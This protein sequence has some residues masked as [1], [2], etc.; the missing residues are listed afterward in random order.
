M[1][2]AHEFPPEVLSA[3]EPDATE[4]ALNSLLNQ[5]PAVY[6]YVA[7]HPNTSEETLYWLWSLDDP[8]L[9]DIIQ[10]RYDEP[11]RGRELLEA[12]GV[13][14][15]ET[16]GVTN[17]P[18]DATKVT[19]PADAPA[20]VPVD[21]P[22]DVPADA[23]ADAP[24]GES[25]VVENDPQATSVMPPVV[26][27]QRQSV[28]NNQ[29]PNY[30][31]PQQQMP[32]AHMPAGYQPGFDRGYGEPDYYMPM[33]P[34]ESKKKSNTALIVILSIV[35]VALIAGGIVLLVFLLK[36]D[37]S[38]SDTP[39][40][41][42]KQTEKTE[43]APQKKEKK[44][45]NDTEAPFAA[46]DN[47]YNDPAFKTPTG[48]IGCL[49]TESGVGCSVRDREV[50][51]CRGQRDGTVTLDTGEAHDDCA[52]SYLKEIDKDGDYIVLDYG[53]TT[54]VGDYAC[55]SEEDGTTCWNTQSGKNFFIAR[56]DWYPGHE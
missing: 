32:P 24:A 30:Y 55:R 38:S 26:A 36:D 56:Q 39:T 6:P 28:Y 12:C 17:V 52:V 27:P 21:A 49:I 31:P 14:L 45:S 41:E 3:L 11:L 13:A 35:L 42:S 51:L 9:Q 18:D 8:A 53:E 16:D 22:T 4:E 23:P 47:A 46:P 2:S 40:A 10:R 29:Q 19:A 48:N 5:N 50:D 25:A 44:A 54:T 20:D 33:P 37:G 15:P 1:S 43:K 7:A 34:E